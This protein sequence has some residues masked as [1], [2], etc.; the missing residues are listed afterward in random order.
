MRILSLLLLLLGV[1]IVDAKDPQIKA[2]IPFSI[3]K[4]LGTYHEIA[5]LPTRFEKG[6]TQITSESYK[7]SEGRLRVRNSGFKADDNVRDSVNG[8]LRFAD[9]TQTQVG[10]LELSF[11]RPFWVTYRIIRIVGD[12]QAFVVMGSDQ[13]S[14]WI[15]A[16][17]PRID[18]L[19]LRQL[20]ADA[21]KQ[22]FPVQALIYSEENAPK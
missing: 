16:R 15:M 21:A 7:D 1:G 19:L 11:F 9:E 13:T 10:E 8:Y 5:R 3:Q 20:V 2:V 14:L 17:T 22:G 4:F 12:Y 6:L 18:P